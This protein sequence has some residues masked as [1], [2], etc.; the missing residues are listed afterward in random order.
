TVPIY[1][2]RGGSRDLN[3][4]NHEILLFDVLAA[5]H[6]RTE[7]RKIGV[8]S[9]S[10]TSRPSIALPALDSSYVVVDYRISNV[11]IGGGAVA[12]SEPHD[13]LFDTT[14]LDKPVDS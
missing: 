4:I 6:D 9:S 3:S 10:P 14:V 8:S 11:A 2:E 5:S 13:D 1:F 7:K 12:S